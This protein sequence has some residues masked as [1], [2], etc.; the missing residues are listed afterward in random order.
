MGEFGRTPR[1]N[2]KTGRDHF[3]QAFNVAMAGGGVKGGQIIGRTTPDG[4]SVKDRPVAV[5][6]LF[7]SF[8]QALKINP[9]KENLSSLGRPIKIIDGGKAVKE[10]FA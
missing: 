5:A 6:D 9:R 3:P 8:Y 4:T 10:L 2:P 7:C 1:I